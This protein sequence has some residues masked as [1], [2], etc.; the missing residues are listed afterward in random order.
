VHGSLGMDTARPDGAPVGQGVR[1][2]KPDQ[3]DAGMS[4]VEDEL[5]SWLAEHW[6]PELTVREWWHRLA[7]A[8]GR[9]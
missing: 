1:M 5:R 6:D 7:M 9:P 8:G 2:T 3:S 4:S